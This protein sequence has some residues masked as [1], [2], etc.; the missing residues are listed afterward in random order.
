MNGR[1][2]RK[3]DEGGGLL[4]RPTGRAPPPV[5]RAPVARRRFS[6][7]VSSA[8]L[9][10]GRNGRLADVGTDVLVLRPRIACRDHDHVVV[11]QQTVR[12]VERVEL[13]EQEARL[14]GEHSLGSAMTP[15]IASE[16]SRN[17]AHRKVGPAHTPGDTLVHVPD[18]SAGAWSPRWRR[19]RARATPAESARQ[20]G[21]PGRRTGPDLDARTRGQDR[22]QDPHHRRRRQR[23]PHRRAPGRLRRPRPGHPPLRDLD[24]GRNPLPARQPRPQFRAVLVGF[25]QSV[26]PGQ[27]CLLRPQESSRQAPQR[28]HHLPGP[29]AHRRPLRDAAQALHPAGA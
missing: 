14:L 23:V 13:A 5:R 27:S 9:P 12:F 7:E 18:A 15:R 2:A 3:G 6:S 25:R 8:A 10:A 24:Q 11:G 26:R 28:R 21:G 19:R 22:H 1:R 4:A 17:P 16:R 20:P 29:T